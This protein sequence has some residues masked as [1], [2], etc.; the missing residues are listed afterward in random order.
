MSILCYEPL[1]Q[2]FKAVLETFS[3]FNIKQNMVNIILS[4]YDLCLYLFL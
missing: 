4:L 3:L 2:L 1:I